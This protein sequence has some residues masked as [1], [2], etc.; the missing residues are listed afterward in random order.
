M[1]KFPRKKSIS[2]YY[3]TGGKGYWF[4]F[5]EAREQENPPLGK[6]KVHRLRWKEIPIEATGN[7]ECYDA[8]DSEI[9]VKNISVHVLSKFLYFLTKLLTFKLD[10]KVK[11][12]ILFLQLSG[13]KPPI[14]DDSTAVTHSVERNE[15][16]KL[17]CNEIAALPKPEVQWFLVPTVYLTLNML[18]PVIFSKINHFY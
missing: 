11:K 1:L 13:P 3:Q 4:P 6:F 18:I 14:L 2:I 12:K 5:E 7:Y 16:V 9:P 15:Q 10:E 17:V 8:I